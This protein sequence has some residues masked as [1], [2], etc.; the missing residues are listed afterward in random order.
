MAAEILFG[1]YQVVNAICLARLRTWAV[2]RRGE[3][4]LV[5]LRSLQEGDA[6]RFEREVARLRRCAHANVCRVFESGRGTSATHGDELFVVTE[7]LDGVAFADHARRTEPAFAARAG[8]QAAMG[9]HAIHELEPDS[10]H[11]DLGAGCLFVT[12]DGVVKIVDTEVIDARSRF[13]YTVSGFRAAPVYLSPER[14]RAEHCDRRSDV[15][16]LA[17]GLW[18]GLADQNLFDR[19]HDVMA[20]IQAALHDPLPDLCALRPD[21]PRGLVAVLERGLARDA[22]ARFA[23]A[24]DFAAALRD[25]VSRNP[26]L[27]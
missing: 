4:Q 8:I 18:S 11:G 23:T 27:S 24:L 25:L 14:M 20:G 17:H 7:Y 2:R 1:R 19:G 9:L 15:Y 21:V 3:S 5:C 13:T 10:L 6:D 12:S 22:D 16:S 26:A